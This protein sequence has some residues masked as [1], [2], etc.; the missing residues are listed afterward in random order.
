MLQAGHVAAWI[1]KGELPPRTQ[2][3]F[4]QLYEFTTSSEKNKE[5]LA[6]FSEEVTRTL[7]AYH[8]CKKTLIYHT[9]KGE[10]DGLLMWYRC[11]DKW[12]WQDIVNWTPDDPTG[13]C[14]FLAFCW[15][16][17][18]ALRN[19]ALE[20]INRQPEVI[21]EKLFS[22]R[23]REDGPQAVEYDQRLLVK[24]LQRNGKKK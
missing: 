19:L 8:F 1:Q 11:N 18:P 6:H 21:R 3:L 12:T 4:S 10:V 14:Y 23:E 16:K 24:I 17:G 20:L 13:N 2:W 5:V 15:A 9:T 22:C 7:I